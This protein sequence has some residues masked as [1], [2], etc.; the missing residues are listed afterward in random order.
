MYVETQLVLYVDQSNPSPDSSHPSFVKI[1]KDDKIHLLVTTTNM[2]L[3][4]IGLFLIP[5]NLLT[6]II[7]LSLWNGFQL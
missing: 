7:M 2:K 5:W 3:L 4:K 6:F 1:S